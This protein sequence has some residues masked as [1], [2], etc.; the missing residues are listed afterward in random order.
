[1]RIDELNLSVRAI[2]CL[3]NAGVCTITDM[4][5]IDLESLKNCGNKTREEIKSKILEL[6][7]QG[8][9]SE[10]FIKKFLSTEADDYVNN[11]PISKRSKNVLSS[12]SITNA[13]QLLSLDENTL[14][15]IRNAGKSSVEEIINYINSNRDSLIK[16]SLSKESSKYKF[17]LEHYTNFSGNTL[18]NSI[19]MSSQL[20]K[21]L[22][23]NNVYSLCELIVNKINVSKFNESEY[24]KIYDYFHN[25]AYGQLALNY[26]N[27]I[28]LCFVKIPFSLKEY[29]EYDN[30]K[31]SDLV[32]YI[33][34]NFSSFTIEEMI[35]AKLYL[36]WLN[37]HHIDNM[38]EYIFEQ[39]ELSDKQESI[40]GKR[41]HMTLEEI[42]NIYGLTR[43]RVRQIESKTNKKIENT[44]KKIPFN[45][46][47]LN[48]I[49]EASL[50]NDRELFLMY[51]D[52]KLDNNFITVKEENKV[53][54][55][56][57]YHLKK[58]EKLLRERKIE[59]EQN[60]FIVYNDKMYPEVLKYTIKY[61]GLNMNNEKISRKINKRQQVKY[62]MRY[63][64]RPINLSTK[65]DLDELSYTV[66][67]L[68]GLELGCNSRALE[69]LI[70]DAGFRV[71]GGTY[72][73]DDNV[74][75]LDIKTLNEIVDYVKQ[76][77]IINARDLFINFGDIFY[78]HNIN[79]DVI[80]YRYL[81]EE[82]TGKLYFH[83]VSAVISCDESLSSW[84]DV[85]IRDITASNKPINKL[86]FIVKYSITEAVYQMLPINFE[87]IIVWSSK[88]LYLK[89]KIFFNDDM[90]RK[91]VF[92]LE[93]KQI[94]TFDEIKKYLKNVQLDFLEINNIRSNINLYY[95]L[96]NV[97]SNDFV[98]DKEKEEVR[99]KRTQTRIIEKSYDKVEELTL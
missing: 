71:D 34:N 29:S 63:M 30:I 58:I 60:G 67:E 77:E 41:M 74:V 51:I 75:P 11:L 5:I 82:L 37:I 36:N 23:C 22:E 12:I 19:P 68:F 97:L 39:L 99:K 80:L 7:E 3:T 79:N 32:N 2:N 18:L 57:K 53:L 35:N 1:M 62:A 43:E 83:G 84:G 69:A 56:P 33:I 45:L 17:F 10:E 21:E 6:Q 96:S 78:N 59:L 8:Y 90:I 25:M 81:K 52:C 85:V 91:F 95:F 24:L 76:K 61:L 44:I 98:I 13:E 72:S 27:A 64:D 49:Y 15:R 73:A 92:Y 4:A 93:E 88:E 65:S 9:Y 50:M 86:D 16:E 14:Y 38:E 28:S 70:M 87:D 40:I 26:S 20:L 48:K 47:N 42:G 31:V 54:F 94:S 66:Y 46:L 89:S 55:V